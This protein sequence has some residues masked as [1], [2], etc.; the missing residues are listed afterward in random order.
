MYKNSRYLLLALPE[1]DINLVSASNL[2]EFHGSFPIFLEKNVFSYWEISIADL[3]F[4]STREY[5]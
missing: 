5:P 3:L 2:L 1:Y 4:V